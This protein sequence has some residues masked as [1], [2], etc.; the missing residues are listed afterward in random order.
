MRIALCSPFSRG[1]LRGN[2]ITVQRIARHLPANGCAVTTIPLDSMDRQ[3]L[4][5]LIA[6]QQPDLLHTFH[7]FHGG[8]VTR[9][10][11]QQHN[12]PYL[13]TMTGS[14]LYDPFFYQ[15]PAT[16]QALQDAAAI[17]CF[18]TLAAEQFSNVFPHLADRL[19]IIPQGIV[20]TTS[21]R[22]Y[23][24]PISGFVVLLPAA[25]RP[26]KG[27]LEAINALAPLATTRPDLELW[28]AGGDLDPAYADRVRHL[29][30]AL[31]WVKLLGEVPH[32]Q[33]PEL[34]GA[35]DVVLNHSR[36]EGGMANTLLEAMA[37]GKTV[38]ASDIPGNRSLV[39]HGETGWLFKEP[40][41]LQELTQRLMDC[42]DLLKTTGQAA[43]SY[44]VSSF[45]PHREAA[46]LAS[47]YRQLVARHHPDR[48]VCLR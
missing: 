11:A 16:A 36:F 14:D 21:S 33:M 42:P 8:Q 43:R 19:A 37:A 23:P 17:T 32:Q 46:A 27:V 18:D 22:P 4:V 1:P 28:I 2:I 34:F 40:H 13:I 25:L 9:L 44:V 47:L 38:I 10:L 26:V 12:L 15:H 41:E 6:R 20:P 31:P 45:S 24:R 3:Q 7:A 39:R 5:D 30:A 35:C 29:S 48:D